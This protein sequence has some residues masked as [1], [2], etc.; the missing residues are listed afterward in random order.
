[1]Y[2][3]LYVRVYIRVYLC[4]R[5]YVHIIHHASRLYHNMRITYASRRRRIIKALN[6][7]LL[8]FTRVTP[9]RS[10]LDPATFFGLDVSE[11]LFHRCR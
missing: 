5:A 1:M 11:F 9:F 6:A 3:T 7:V 2:Y 10:F 4:V 8:T